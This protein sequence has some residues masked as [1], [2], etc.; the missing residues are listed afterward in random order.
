MADGVFTYA[1]ELIWSIIFGTA[2]ATTL[3]LSAVL[4]CSITLFPCSRIVGITLIAVSI[5]F[6]TFG[7]SSRALS[8]WS[9][10]L[11]PR[12]LATLGIMSVTDP[13]SVF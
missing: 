2:S 3:I 10:S 4:F 5:P 6:L 12:S 7:F 9:L 13:G 8:A 1:F 11:F